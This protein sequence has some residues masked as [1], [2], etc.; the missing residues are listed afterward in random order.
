ML[1]IHGEPTREVVK[2]SDRNA[3][4]GRLLLQKLME[5]EKQG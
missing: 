5:A 1:S 4:R 3:V 2:F